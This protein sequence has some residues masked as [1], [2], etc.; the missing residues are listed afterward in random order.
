MKVTNVKKCANRT[1]TNRTLQPLDQQQQQLEEEVQTLTYPNCLLLL[2]STSPTTTRETL[3]NLTQ[4]LQN[5]R[6]LSSR[7]RHGPCQL[8]HHQ[9]PA[10]PPWRQ[11]VGKPSKPF[12]MVLDTG[13][14]VNWLQCQPCSDCYQQSDPIF[15]PS[16]SVS[17]NPLSCASS[18]CSLLDRGYTDDSVCV[19]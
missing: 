3:Q 6:P 15:N 10:R 13:S 5:P 11:E 14:D 7:A 1:K 16:D 2:S 8:A 9:A 18:Q 17:Y 4:G 19:G 12:Y